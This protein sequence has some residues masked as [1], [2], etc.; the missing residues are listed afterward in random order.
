MVKPITDKRR[1]Y[2]TASINGS[3]K[4]Q[5]VSVSNPVELKDG[6]IRWNV[7][8]IDGTKYFENEDNLSNFCM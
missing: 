1:F 8:E 5:F 2:K 7:E 6:S 3:E 4:L